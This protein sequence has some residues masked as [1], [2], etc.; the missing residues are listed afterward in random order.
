[1]TLE[2]R[3]VRLRALEPSDAE[4]AHQ[5]IN[6][7]EVTHFLMARYPFSLR[8]EQR[9]LE[10]A[11]GSTGFTDIRLAIETKDGE[12]I[13]NMGLH[14]ASPEDRNAE[15][16][17][18]IGEKAHWSSGCGTDAILTLLRFAFHQMN[19]HRVDLGVFE[20]NERA[21]ACY[22]KCGFVEEG[23]RRE[24]Y[25]QDG[26][27]WDIVRMGVLRREFEALHGATA[28]GEPARTNGA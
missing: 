24:A 8:D 28:A 21:I 15:L 26:R 25:F 6:D 4:R 9:W 19:L 5:W 22:R 7:R 2:G 12:H 14:R 1:M 18:M 13:G 11:S 23:R 16:G 20:F 3:L 10:E 17:I 27:Y